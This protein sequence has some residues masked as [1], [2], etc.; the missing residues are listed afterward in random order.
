VKVDISAESKNKYLLR[1]NGSTIKFDGYLKVYGD[2]LPVTENLLPELAEK[3]ILDLVAVTAEQKFSS[4]P[5]RYSE[6]ALVKAMEEHGIGRPSTYAPT[7]ATIMERA[8]VDKNEAKRLFPLEIGFLVNDLLVEHFP[9]IVDIQ[10][11][12]KMESEFDEIAENKIEWVP[13]IRA[14]YEPFHK[15][16]ASKQDSVKKED[17]LEK[18]EKPC[19]KCGGDLIVKFGRFGKFIACANF[20]NCKYTEKTADEK[21]VDAENSGVV[22]DKC[23]APMV[24]KRGKFGAFLGC[25]KY[26][27]CK[28]IKRIEKSTGLKCPK[29]G[30]GEIAERKSK[31]GKLFYGCTAYPNC[32]FALW[33]KPTGE[34]CPKCSS[35]LVF[36]AKGQSRCSNK[37][38]SSSKA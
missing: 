9:Q 13:M 5:P 37:E 25:S 19:P 34:K 12:A 30:K 2:K 36:A 14:F 1:A 6:A 22:C 8:Y 33:S 17:Y 31:R 21:K 24:V 35:L 20:P 29:C 3:E 23:G 4:A 28:G 16:L 27:D 38:C 10:F 32:D 11:T 18:L 15:N 26:P 7:L